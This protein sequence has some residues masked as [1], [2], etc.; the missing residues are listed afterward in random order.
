MKPDRH[1]H[2]DQ[3][4]DADETT[5]R[6]N[7]GSRSSDMNVTPLIDV[8]LVLLVIF[9]AALPLTQRGIDIQLPLDTKAETTKSDSTQVVVERSADLQLTVNKQVIQLTEL[10][11][12]LRGIFADRKDKS[13][14][15]NAAGT[16]KYG[17]VVPL[18]DAATALGLR[19]G[20]ITPDMQAG[21]QR[22]K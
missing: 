18:L 6:R 16:L 12:R 15:I 14:F 4:D 21:A 19:I 1:K 20:I 11:G 8:L 7:I 9:I 22:A 3:H 5:V 17:D 10:E 2:H 13:V